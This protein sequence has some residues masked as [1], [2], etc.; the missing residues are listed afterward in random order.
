MEVAS[1]SFSEGQLPE[2]DRSRGGASSFQSQ[3][4][5][6]IEPEN[7]GTASGRSTLLVDKHKA[8]IKSLDNVSSGIQFQGV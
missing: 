7:A 2:R 8:Y 6:E 1:S 5:K 3:G 4:V